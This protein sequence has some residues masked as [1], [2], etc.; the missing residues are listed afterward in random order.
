[1]AFDDEPE[2]NPDVATAP[3]GRKIKIREFDGAGARRPAEEPVPFRI[4]SGK[5]IKVVEF[6][7]GKARR[8][9]KGSGPPGI[10]IVEFD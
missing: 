6:E 2:D 7:D 1:M 9:E 10:K 3:G 4:P 5:S 8:R